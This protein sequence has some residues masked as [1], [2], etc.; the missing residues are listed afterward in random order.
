[1]MLGL[2]MTG[3]VGILGLVTCFA[4]WSISH[5]TRIRRV[6]SGCLLGLG[7]VLLGL[8]G[9]G[10]WYLY[11][12]Q[13]S[14]IVGQPLFYG[15]TYTREVSTRPRP[16]VVHILTIDLHSPTLR[17]LVTP[18]D[19]IGDHQFPARTTSQ[20]LDEFGVQ[21]A[22]NGGYYYPFHGKLLSYHPHVGDPVSVL[23]YAMS[24]GVAYS[25]HEPSYTTCYI[26]RTNQV[27]IGKMREDSYNALSGYWVFVKDG[28]V[29]EDL[30]GAYYANTPGARTAVAIDKT[31]RYML[32]LVVDGRQPNYSEGM[33]L[34]ELG[35]V[36][37]RHGAALALN[38]DNG[39]STT[40]VMEGTTG[41]PV[42]LNTPIHRR[43]P[44]GRERPVANHLG[45]FAAP[46]A[47]E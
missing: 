45:L 36:A 10:L 6:M 42:L 34:V 8:C 46:F 24:E 1:M 38:L 18:P 22:I 17:F 7:V 28:Q 11:R 16:T 37:V 14:P 31:G 40:L 15:V 21:V 12:P 9:Y 39:G 43:I 27:S 4:G 33:T 41:Q 26:S 47:N 5:T 32:W 13:P 35:V 2:L 25:E 20:F 19:P 44:P 3:L 23:G 30:G 29:V